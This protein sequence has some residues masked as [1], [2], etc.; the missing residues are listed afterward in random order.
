MTMAELDETFEKIEK[1]AEMISGNLD[2]ELILDG[3]PASET[4]AAV[5]LLCI[6][7][8]STQNAISALVKKA[9]T[10]AESLTEKKKSEIPDPPLQERK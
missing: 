10:I 9:G 7:A 3:R 8:M 1:T 6:H 5:A 2:K 4:M